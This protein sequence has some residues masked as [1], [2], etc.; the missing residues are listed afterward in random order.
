MSNDP[1]S[2]GLI[3]MGCEH[4]D[5]LEARAR[6]TAAGIEEITGGGDDRDKLARFL[7]PDR[8][9]VTFQL[10]NPDQRFHD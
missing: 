10:F 1:P 3:L 8:R 2:S 6:A 7:D 9:I 4:A 5:D